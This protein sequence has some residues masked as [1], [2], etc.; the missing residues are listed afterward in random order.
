MGYG[1]QLGVAFGQQG[2]PFVSPPPPPPPPEQPKRSMVDEIVASI[3]DDPNPGMAS[4]SLESLHHTITP[5]F[6]NSS[7]YTGPG[8]HWTALND[9]FPMDD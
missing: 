2:P 9:Y 1:S 5:P 8:A 7:I 4:S 3:F 6:F